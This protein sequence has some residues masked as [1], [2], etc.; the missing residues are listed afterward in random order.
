MHGIIHVSNDY[1]IYEY[2]TRQVYIIY[3]GTD[4]ILYYYTHLLISNI[5]TMYNNIIAY[6]SRVIDY[7][8][9]VIYY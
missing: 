1:N 2:A 8:T 3:I 6:A 4:I 7:R 9:D 5:T